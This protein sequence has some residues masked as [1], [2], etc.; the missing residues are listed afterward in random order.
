MRRRGLRIATETRPAH[1]LQQ[2][3]CDRVD[4]SVSNHLLQVRARC[5]EEVC[6]LQTRIQL[7]FLTQPLNVI[8]RNGRGLG[9]HIYPGLLL[10]YWHIVRATP[11]DS[12]YRWRPWKLSICSRPRPRGCLCR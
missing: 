10:G 12:A 11:N 6:V 2:K 3:L 7:S 5:E 1:S 4:M 8:G 9:Y